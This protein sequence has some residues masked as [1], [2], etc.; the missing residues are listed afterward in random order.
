MVQAAMISITGTQQLE[1]EEP[2]SIIHSNK[3]KNQPH[4]TITEGVCGVGV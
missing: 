3:K 4:L 1:G 2:E